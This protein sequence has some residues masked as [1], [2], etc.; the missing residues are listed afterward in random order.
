MKQLL[1]N[2]KD[3]IKKGFLEIFPK[4][5]RD[6]LAGS[7][8]SEAV[9]NRGHRPR[10]LTRALTAA[11]KAV[12]CILLLLLLLGCSTQ[13]HVVTQLKE[14]TKVDTIYLNTFRFDSTYVYQGLEK[15]YRRDLHK[16]S[17][18][19]PQPLV[20][21]LLIRE[22]NTEFRYKLLRDT[23]ERIK[24]EVVHDSIPYEVVVYKDPINHK[25]STI[26]RLR[27]WFDRLSRSVFWIVIVTIITLV[28]SKG[29][30]IV[31]KPIIRKFR[32][33]S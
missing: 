13:R 23:V 10:I 9:I 12:P 7:Q 2:I 18:I 21:T 11:W 19:N 6:D 8:Y 20:D 14:V 17:T 31:A 30:T 24:I 27:T 28:V 25:P 32:F 4:Y 33:L 29:R 1:I 3:L 22:T 26:N 15:D 16:A 5:S